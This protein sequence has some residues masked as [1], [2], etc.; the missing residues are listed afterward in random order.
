M[1]GHFI[2]PITDR[3]TRS[4]P[5]GGKQAAKAQRETN[6]KDPIGMKGVASKQPKVEDR[7]LNEDMVLLTTKVATN[8]EISHWDNYGIPVIS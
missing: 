3:Y 1:A 5:P 7:G 8:I 2:L 4:T 6:E